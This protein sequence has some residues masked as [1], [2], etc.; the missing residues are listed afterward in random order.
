VHFLLRLPIGNGS[1][2]GG[3]EQL[4]AHYGDRSA[5]DSAGGLQLP[6]HRPSR[7]GVFQYAGV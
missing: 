5:A 7:A 3:G 2:T 1:P 6:S 4:A